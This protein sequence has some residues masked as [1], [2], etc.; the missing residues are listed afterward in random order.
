VGAVI[1]GGF[2]NLRELHMMKYKQA[3]KTKDN[4]KWDEAVF[5]KDE[6]MVTTSV[7]MNVPKEKVPKKAKIISSTF[8]P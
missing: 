2:A 3:M 6:R 5:E 4:D 8:R 7:L 1:G